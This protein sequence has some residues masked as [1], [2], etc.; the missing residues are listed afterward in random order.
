MVC[1]YLDGWDGG[2]REVQEGGGLGIHITCSLR[3]TTETNIA[4]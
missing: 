1:G 3:C 4:L 2:W